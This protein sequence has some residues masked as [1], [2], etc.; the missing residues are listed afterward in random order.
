MV[1]KLGYLRLS[2]YWL[3]LANDWCIINIKLSCQT[4]LKTYAANSH[5]RHSCIGE[6]ENPL[7]MYT[8]PVIRPFSNLDQ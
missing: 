4:L 1:L 7:R 8:A 6:P 3:L 5:I 2:Q